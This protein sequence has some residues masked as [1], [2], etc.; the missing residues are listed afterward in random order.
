MDLFK[1]NDLLSKGQIFYSL[2]GYEKAEPKGLL[3]RELT[4]S[5][6]YE[7]STATVP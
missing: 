2:Y 7:W 4:E 5:E 1:R 3:E 6:G